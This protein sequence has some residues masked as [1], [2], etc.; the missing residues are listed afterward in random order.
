[1]WCRVP[2]LWLFL[3]WLVFSIDIV[4]VIGDSSVC[5][6]IVIDGPTP[7]SLSEYA[8]CES[9]DA[10]PTGV[11]LTITNSNLIDLSGLN[12]VTTIRGLV[13]ITGNTQLTSLHGMDA[14]QTI[15]GSLTLLRNTALTSIASLSNLTSLMQLHVESCPSL[16]SLSGLERLDH[17]YDLRIADCA[18]L[19]SMV[20]LGGVTTIGDALAFGFLLGLTILNNP[21]L[22]TLNGLNALRS[23]PGVFT[24]TDNNGLTSLAGLD[25]LRFVS[26]WTIETNQGLINLHGISPT[27]ALT[28]LLVNSN[29][30]LV[31]L[32]GLDGLQSARSITIEGN[33][34]LE[35][36]S[37]LGSLASVT[38]L[39]I[40]SNT[41]LTSL[42]GL[43]ALTTVDGDFT[44]ITNTYLNDLQGLNAL[45]TIAGTC[46]ITDN[47][48]YTLDG[49]E[50]ID[51]I[52]ILLISESWLESMEALLHLSS[53]QST[54]ALVGSQYL[55]CPPSTFYSKLDISFRAFLCTSCFTVESV[56]PLVVPSAGGVS[57]TIAYDGHVQRNDISAR[58]T[59][60]ND[61][62]NADGPTLTSSFSNV[63]HCHVDQVTPIITCQ[64]VGFPYAIG[65][66]AA[67]AMLGA[68]WLLQ[69]SMDGTNWLDYDSA[70]LRTVSFA[71]W[72]QLTRDEMM[73]PAGIESQAEM[74]DELNL[75]PSDSSHEVGDS[76]RY[77]LIA[78]FS[79]VVGLLSLLLIV[80]F[81]RNLSQLLLR[82]DFLRMPRDRVDHGSVSRVLFERSAVGGIVTLLTCGTLI[83]VI[84]AYIIQVSETNTL[85]T[86]SNNPGLVSRFVPSTFTASVAVHPVRA[87]GTIGDDPCHER[88]IALDAIGFT[89]NGQFTCQYD[90]AGDRLIV[91]WSC[92]DCY[93]I[94]PTGNL[95]LA[96]RHPNAFARS[97]DWSF[98]SVAFSAQP[99]LVSGRVHV[100]PLHYFK[101]LPR[102]Q[103]LVTTLRSNFTYFDDDTQTGV[104]S[105]V[106]AQVAGRSVD[107]SGFGSASGVAFEIIVSNSPDW[108]I[109][110]Y[111]SKQT[112]FA[113]VA[114]LF[115]IAGGIIAA[116]RFML[117]AYA[118]W[119]RNKWDNDNNAETDRDDKP[120]RQAGNPQ[121]DE[122]QPESL[123]PHAHAHAPAPAPA[124]I[125]EIELHSRPYTHVHPADDKNVHSNAGP[126][127]T[128]L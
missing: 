23:V 94:Q 32:S 73:A 101:G 49:L 61:E 26:R 50:S 55:C 125:A 93:H 47:S 105:K 91:D 114:Q 28:T 7:T 35:N 109:I 62:D 111:T 112:T 38:T 8:H 67:T 13:S 71:N 104:L 80:L 128:R 83:V 108:F 72:S 6:P 21:N 69:L 106:D 63:S 24:L 92:T 119:T 77:T 60:N 85:L 18:S 123:D 70:V 3:V 107:E 34:G 17:L 87:T 46:T 31:D 82:I 89:T 40:L 51:T 90:V 115:A 95:S 86:T 11:S 19:T 25:S 16:T 124:S 5:A 84:V 54:F 78:G 2:L 75:L 9:I 59:I 15:A 121:S 10:D 116:G 79:C 48:L 126:Y 53:V 74:P 122:P 98:G 81:S 99:S 29:F 14:L 22:T 103:A 52:G 36:L 113:I 4:G 39:S 57:L 41:G 30:A 120:L 96:F 110:A 102:T 68:D 58:F 117:V 42:H 100:A 44:I 64:L 127:S 56:S 88:S 27:F 118:A 43:E 37:G 97:F 76:M 45:T 33:T 12:N 66:D 1:M 65:V 20:G